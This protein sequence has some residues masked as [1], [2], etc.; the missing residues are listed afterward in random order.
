MLMMMMMRALLHIAIITINAVIVVTSAYV[1]DRAGQAADSQPVWCL[2]GGS[3]SWLPSAQIKWVLITCTALD[4]YKC[5]Y[6][7]VT[8]NC[9]TGVTSVWQSSSLSDTR[10][11]HRTAGSSSSKGLQTKLCLVSIIIYLCIE[12]Q[13]PDREENIILYL[14]VRKQSFQWN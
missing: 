10:P 2:R 9:D 6:I 3:S 12:C 13:Y 5:H 4:L 7:I 8:C 1:D 14:K 11:E